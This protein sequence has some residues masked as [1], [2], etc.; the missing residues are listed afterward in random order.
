FI[1]EQMGTQKPAADFYEKIAAQISGFQFDQALM[2]G[3]SL[4]ADI[5]GGNNAGM[6]T[7][8]YNPTHMINNSK[9]VP[10]YTISSYQELLDLL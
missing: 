3:D 7:V 8:W 2:I 10:T 6:D 4:T 1:S 5:Q 9:A